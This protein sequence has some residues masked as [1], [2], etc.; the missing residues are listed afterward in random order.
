MADSDF[1]K[2]P[3]VPDY[4]AVPAVYKSVGNNALGVGTPPAYADEITDPS[5][6]DA[7]GWAQVGDFSAGYL[8]EGQGATEAKFRTHI[9]ATHVLRDDPIRN[10]GMPGTSPWHMFLGNRAVNAWST[11]R[12]VRRNATS[13]AAGGP[14]NGTGYWIPALLAYDG[15]DTYATVPD[16]GAVYYA[17]NMSEADELVR[18]PRGLR[19]VTGWNMDDH[20]DAL[21]T[22]EVTAGGERYDLPVSNGFLGWK[23]VEA[24]ADGGETILTTTGQVYSP[25]LKNADNSDPW[26]GLAVP[27][28]RIVAV[29]HAPEFW[30]GVNL[31]SPGG[32]KH[33]RH[34]VH[35]DVLGK[36]VGPDGWYRVPRLELTFWYSHEGFADYGNRRL[37][38]DD[39]LSMIDPGHAPMR[40]GSTMHMDWLGG[41]DAIFFALWQQ[42]GLGVDGG[43]PHQMNDSVVSATQRLIV[44]ETAPDGRSP[45]VNIGQHLT[46][47]RILLPA[48]G[49]GRGPY[50]ITGRGN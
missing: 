7:T 17:T 23:C 37:A 15:D 4:V 16:F 5:P 21:H 39:H 27:G 34:G 19:Y 44:S 18:L 9:N 10:Y 25:C 3:D 6:T 22:A 38:S 49:A 42:N 36:T 31:W 24:D 40:N 20:H 33:F 43:T 41:W 46:D 26:G 47:T 45:Q 14:L 32:Y 2:P 35:D 12:S 50:T 48:S 29:L 1:P 13:S 11:Y 28:T 8:T 30:D